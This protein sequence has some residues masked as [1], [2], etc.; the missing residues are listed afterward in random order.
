AKLQAVSA[1]EIPSRPRHRHAYF[2][3]QRPGVAAAPGRL[4]VGRTSRLPGDGQVIRA[5]GKRV[6]KVHATDRETDRAS[7]QVEG[8]ATRVKSSVRRT[9]SVSSCVSTKT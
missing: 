9:E 2:L 6:A 5:I 3:E 7:R 8:V 1:R 4:R